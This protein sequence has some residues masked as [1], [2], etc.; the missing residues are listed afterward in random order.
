MNPYRNIIQ[1]TDAEQLLEGALLY[2]LLDGKLLYSLSAETLLYRLSEGTLLYSLLEGTLLYRLSEGTLLYR[3]SEGTLLYS[4]LEGTLLYRLS[5]GHCCDTPS[6]KGRERYVQTDTVKSC[7]L[8]VVR[9]QQHR[10]G[11][12]S[13]NHPSLG[14]SHAPAT[15]P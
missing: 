10:A 14:L 4:L 6:W 2:S 1:L 7:S 11:G 3:L 15:T 9:A 13:E 5:E 12:Y 8:V